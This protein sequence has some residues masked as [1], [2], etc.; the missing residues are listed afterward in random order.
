MS[1]RVGAEL[2]SSRCILLLCC[3][4]PWR[5]EEKRWTAAED[6]A[7]E[8]PGLEGMGAD[9]ETVG[10]GNLRISDISNINSS[11]IVFTAFTGLSQAW[12]ALQS[13]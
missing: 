4:H 3:L 5:G 8:D 12:P 11:Q 10:C 1:G 7:I 9:G 13:C 6:L 2:L